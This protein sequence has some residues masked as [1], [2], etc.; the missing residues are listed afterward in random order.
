MFRLYEK[1]SNFLL[2]EITEDQFEFLSDLL[3]EESS[4]DTDYYITQD[5]LDL[6]EAEGGDPA[7][8]K[9]LR[10]ALGEREDMEIRWEKKE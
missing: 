5:T 3:E 1:G 4:S 6:F 8:T 7:L 9:M 10:D 2:G